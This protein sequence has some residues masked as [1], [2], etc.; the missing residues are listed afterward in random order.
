MAPVYR[1]YLSDL[2][3]KTQ[4]GQEFQNYDNFY[5]DWQ[6]TMQFGSSV[7]WKVIGGSNFWPDQAE[8]YETTK[9][10]KVLSGKSE[11]VFNFKTLATFTTESEFELTCLTPQQ[12]QES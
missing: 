6:L 10:V 4:L 8:N 5:M 12:L 9:T 7:N 2:Y 1:P 11:N 3:S